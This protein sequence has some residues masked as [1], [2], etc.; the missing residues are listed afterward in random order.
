MSPPTEADQLD[1]HE[2][3]IGFN[4][5]Q[6]RLLKSE[7]E[8]RDEARKNEVAQILGAVEK[9]SRTME[10]IKDL[11]AHPE[12]G[13]ASRLHTLEEHHGDNEDLKTQLQVLI[14]R[15]GAVS[16]L[17]KAL[18]PKVLGGLTALV[19]ALAVSWA[20]LGGVPFSFEGLG[21]KLSNQEA[22]ETQPSGVGERKEESPA[23]SG[24]GE[25]KEKVPHTEG[26]VLGPNPTP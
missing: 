7:A 4:E 2:K 21:M 12:T 1:D 17:Q 19:L 9:N 20:L 15:P 3:R 18:E 6:L 11:L 10:A 14:D 5:G 22:A 25:K 8:F 13:I 16:L 23:S 26:G 24:V